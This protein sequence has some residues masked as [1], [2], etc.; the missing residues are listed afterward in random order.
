MLALVAV[1]GVFVVGA[2][3]GT[4]PSMIDD[5]ARSVVSAGED[6][7]SGPTVNETEVAQE[8]HDRVNEFRQ[9]RGL[10]PLSWE[11]A[12][13]QIATKHSE[14]MA[15]QSYYAHESPEGN[16]FEDRYVQ[17]SYNCRVESRPGQDYGGAENIAYTH[18]TTDVEGPSGE[19]V[20]DNG[21]ETKLP[22]GIVNQ[23]MNSPRHREILLQPFWN[24]EGI[25]VAVTE[26]SNGT[27]VLATQNF[28]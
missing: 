23:W 25:G 7:A 12:P 11:R 19:T 5:T 2:T 21:N 24:A 9:Q 10:E 8:I 1:V 6:I 26:D 17:A 13:H 20:N 4:G 22:H 27:K 3:V 28:C 16:D 15:N 14:D 18:A